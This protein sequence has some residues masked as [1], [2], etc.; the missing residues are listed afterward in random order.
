[1]WGRPAWRHGL[2]GV[3]VV[4]SLVAAAAPVSAQTPP[5]APPPP[6]RTR[7]RGTGL[8]TSLFGT[9]VR[10]G[11]LIV[12][13][14]YEYYRDKDFEYSPIELGFGPDVE[15]RGRYRAHEGLIYVAYGLSDRVAIEVEA[16]V[17][18]AELHKSPVDGS[19][20]PARIHESGVGD[21][22]GQVRWRWNRESDSRPEFFSYAEVVVPHHRNK[23][24]IGT[25]GWEL[26]Y[27][28]GLVRG[29]GWG[30]LTVRGAVEY[31]EASSS[32]FDG[33]EYAVEVL[34]RLS[35]AWRVYAGLE[36]TTDEVA[37][38]G[39]LQ[40]HVSRHAFVRFNNGFGVSSKATDWAPEVG[41]V[42][43]WTRR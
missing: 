39:E 15:Y 13:P 16:A 33:G 19:A 29:F 26:K 23:V 25:P 34:R 5:P 32:H 30:T 42:F 14:F 40:W 18:T 4:A 35:D 6:D 10:G 43:S 12:Y 8:P 28:T 36:G 38:I 11:E 31:S 24:L 2:S 17:I 1:M 41:V 37:L 7:D 21:V 20:V 22:E 27:G 3:V 9:Y